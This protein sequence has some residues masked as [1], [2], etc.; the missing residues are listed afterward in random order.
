MNNDKTL[1]LFDVDNTLCESSK[2]IKYEHKNMLLKLMEKYDLGLISGGTYEK[3]YEQFDQELWNIFIHSFNENGN[4]YRK[5]NKLI[6]CRDIK[7]EYNIDINKVILISTNILRKHY[8]YYDENKNYFYIRKGLI[9]LTFIGTI[10]QDDNRKIFI[11]YEKNNN[12]RKHILKLINKEFL[13]N[14]INWTI[15]FGG[16]TGL[17]LCPKGWTKSGIFDYF[18]EYDKIIFFGDNIVKNGNDYDIAMSEHVTKYYWVKNY[19]QTYDLLG[20]EITGE[21][22]F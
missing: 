4:V 17:S 5:N 8:P 14:G 12:I 9:Y 7:D 20:S 16:Q 2:K 15:R 1:L 6:F 21:I 22:I 11:K 19:K 18:N 13:Y 3:V 10:G